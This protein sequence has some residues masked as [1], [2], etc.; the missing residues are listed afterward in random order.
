MLD[1]L[2]ARLTYANVMATIAVFV[3]LGGSSYAA[4]K[5]SGKNVK[6]RSLTGRDVK[7]NSLT[8]KEIKESRLGEVP[9]ARS[10]TSAGTAATAGT[11][12]SASTAGSADTAN[13]A[14]NL[15]PGE[16][17]HEVGAPGEPAF[18]NGC[19]NLS[20]STRNTV[21]FYKDHEGVVH[22]KG[23]VSCPGTDI[24]AFQLPEGYRP[25]TGKALALVGAATGGD[26]QTTYNVN[27]S[28]LGSSV[29]GA[30]A[31]AAANQYSLDG[32]T[33]RAGS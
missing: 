2:R 19:T 22:L 28:G 7:K 27:G 31:S 4:I 5:V 13:T 25:A 30:V 20:G 3:A 14:S 15:A 33:F 32:G 18:E 1:Q 26:G 10:A 9:R 6:D 16:A 21:G 24:A 29:D 23:W 12:G 17:F 8:G 11:A